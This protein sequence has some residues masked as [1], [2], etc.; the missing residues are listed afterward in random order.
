MGKLKKY[1]HII[2]AL[3]LAAGGGMAGWWFINS[4]TPTEKVVVT[5]GNLAV[6]TVISPS[7]VTTKLVAKSVMPP[8]TITKPEEVVGKTLTMSVLGDEI[9]RKEHIITGKG[10]L[11]ARLATIAPGRVAV[12]LPPE[13]AQGL[14]GLEIGDIVNIYGEVG[15]A[16]PDGK[17]ATAVEKVATGSIILYAPRTDKTDSIK[18]S[19][20]EAIIIACDPN[21]EQKIAD[22]LT[23]G[24]KVSVFL[25]QTKGDEK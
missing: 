5:Q 1:L 19:K 13:S 17:G 12:D 16:G 24:K 21:E 14:K 20:N 8:N 10:S 11:N 15:I 9:L 25:Q 6:G 2:L 4:N 18:S 22:V 7:H 3:I 23:R